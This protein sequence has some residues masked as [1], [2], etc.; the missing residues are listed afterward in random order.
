[1]RAPRCFRSPRRARRA[2]RGM[3][4]IE[5]ILALAILGMGLVALMATTAQGLN[6]GRRSKRYEISRELLGRVE[7]EDPVQLEEDIE[8]AEGDGDFEGAEYREYRWNRTVEIVGL[9][10][11]ALY[12]ITTSVTWP[13]GP[14]N[15]AET[16][17][18][19]VHAPERRRER[20][21]EN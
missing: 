20:A 8:D 14:S 5:V 9:E 17:V 15:R 11:D 13:D 21:G 4:L 7:L 12:M 10:E 3:T 18:T 19:Y 6:A 2:R 16:I 1:M